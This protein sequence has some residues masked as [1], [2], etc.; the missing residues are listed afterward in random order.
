MIE[1]DINLVQPID[2]EIAPVVEFTEEIA[3]VIEFTADIGV[4]GV[5]HIKPE[6]LEIYDG[7]I[8]V[9]PKANE[10]T[11]LPTAQKLVEDDITVMEIPFYQTTNPQGGNTIYIGR[12]SEVI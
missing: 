1:C 4:G 8:T 12:E 6:D 9:I 2:G 10:Q 7:D 3:P 11:I 5:I